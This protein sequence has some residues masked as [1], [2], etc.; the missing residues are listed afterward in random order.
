[1]T[2]RVKRSPLLIRLTPWRSATRNGPRAPAPAARDGEDHAVPLPEA[3]DLGA[4]LHP[5][6]LLGQHE[7][8]AGKIP[9]RR[10]EQDC[11]LQRKPSAP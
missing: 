1:M 4:R 6:P 11:D 7:L 5:R 3:H 8:A 10:G 9:P 2:P